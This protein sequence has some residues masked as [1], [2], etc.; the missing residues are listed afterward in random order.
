MSYGNATAFL[1]SFCLLLNLIFL[2][3]KVIVNS[4][5]ESVK[6]LTDVLILTV[7]CLSVFAL[8]GLQLFM[9]NLTSKCVLN[10]TIY[11][12]TLC[13]D[14]KIYIPNDEGKCYSFLPLHNLCIFLSM[15]CFFHRDVKITVACIS[16]KKVCPSI[17]TS[18]NAKFLGQ[19]NVQLVN[20]GFGERLAVCGIEGTEFSI[21]IC[22]FT[23]ARCMRILILGV[24]YYTDNYFF[25]HFI[26]II[27]GFCLLL[28]EILIFTRDQTTL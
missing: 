14:A 17:C 3:L 20:L 11:N 9:G 7:F 25:H 1:F 10:N 12:D 24:R 27:Q 15:S 2:G 22:S 13:K 5:V 16:H 26:Y 18:S 4:L 19:L 8:I 6:K 28:A 21:S 23:Y